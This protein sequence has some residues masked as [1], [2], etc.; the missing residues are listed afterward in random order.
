MYYN[1][2]QFDNLLSSFI[3]S[4]WEDIFNETNGSFRVVNNVLAKDLFAMGAQA[5]QANFSSYQ[6][7]SGGKI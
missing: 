1:M 3:L 2:Y 6:P 5:S 4:K 7:W